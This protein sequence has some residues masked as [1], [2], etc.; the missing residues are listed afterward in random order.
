MFG[1][2]Y[3]TR[4]IKIIWAYGKDGT[5]EINEEDLREGFRRRR[6]GPKEKHGT[7]E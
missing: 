6:G 2:K 1:N 4:A 7:K 3:R 5:G